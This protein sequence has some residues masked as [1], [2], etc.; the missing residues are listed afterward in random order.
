MPGAALTVGWKIK[1]GLFHSWKFKS[2]PSCTGFHPTRGRRHGMVCRASLMSKYQYDK[3]CAYLEDTYGIQ[4]KDFGARVMREGQSGADVLA[5]QEFLSEELYLFG[6]PYD[7]FK[8]V[9]GYF[10]GSTKEA[11][12]SWQRDVG[13]PPT[14]IF[15]FTSKMMY[16]QYMEDKVSPRTVLDGVRV[17]I[18]SKSPTM[19]P[20]GMIPV[21]MYGVVGF[22]AICGVLAATKMH[23]HLKRYL[24]TVLPSIWSK[25][26]AASL[27]MAP[28]PSGVPRV[29]T[30]PPKPQRL[31][32][33]E[34]DMRLAPMKNI[35]HT[36]PRRA[37]GGPAPR[38]EP[39]P[40]SSPRPNTDIARDDEGIQTRHGTYYGGRQ[41]WNTIRRGVEDNEGV[42]MPVAKQESMEQLGYRMTPSPSSRPDTH[43]RLLEGTELETLPRDNTS[44]KPG[45]TSHQEVENVVMHDPTTVILQDKPVKLHKPTRLL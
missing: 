38:R 10:G 28:P 26:T 33:E 5:L 9:N 19:S 40:S 8:V 21:H 36:R 29:E 20:T 7:S 1:S 11:L 34:L 14:G 31:S 16:T 13:L 4:V 45:D 22:L 30:T 39:S 35:E 15:D 6:N 2:S 18:V 41:V 25:T 44:K 24:S 37:R 17:G 12:Q 43:A 27:E 3:R 42:S 23:H 32:R